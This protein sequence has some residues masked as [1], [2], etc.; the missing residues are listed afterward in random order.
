M[1]S[2]KS[3]QDPEMRSTSRKTQRNNERTQHKKEK[4]TTH[5]QGVSQGI[6]LFDKELFYRNCSGYNFPVLCEHVPFHAAM[7]ARGY[8]KLFILPPLIYVS[9]H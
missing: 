2:R 3:A 8:D 9:D 1:P 4:P 5:I 7:I 6:Y